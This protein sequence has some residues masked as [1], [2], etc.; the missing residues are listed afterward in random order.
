MKLKKSLLTFSGLVRYYGRERN[1]KFKVSLLQ[2]LR[3]WRR[4]FCTDSAVYYDFEAF[5]RPFFLTEYEMYARAIRIN[6]GYTEVMNNKLVFNDLLEGL[7]RTATVY[8]YVEKGK[9][10]P[11]RGYPEFC[12]SDALMQLLREGQLL[13]C[14]AFVGSRGQG[15]F[16]LSYR[17]GHYYKSGE[18]ITPEELETLI[19]S[20]DQYMICDFIEQADYSNEVCAHTGNTIKVL[21]MID[22]ETNEA[23]IAA[24]AHRFGTTK[25][26][27]VD[28]YGEGGV[29]GVIDPE[30]GVIYDAF[31]IAEGKR[32]KVTH[33][34]ETKAPIVGLQIPRWSEFR[35][36]VL[37]LANKLSY[38]KYIAW[39]TILQNDG[40]T[41]VEG[42]TNSNIAIFQALKPLLL[43]E[44]NRAFYRHHGVLRRKLPDSS[45]IQERE[46]S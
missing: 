15:V 16:S 20:L 22:P 5:G 42:N 27:P 4:G 18:T 31:R 39:D 6:T 26:Q 33:H 7:A 3:M 14:K 2:R 11:H 35:E 19:Q 37:A 46:H 29:C 32:V 34:H 36:E 8:G 12:S 38:V 24:A 9:I 13:L 45:E 43:E 30:T 25:S 1:P 10:R 41:V 28:A 21:T 40:F 44:R 23:F 17:D